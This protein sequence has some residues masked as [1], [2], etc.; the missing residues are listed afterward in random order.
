MVLPFAPLPRIWLDNHLGECENKIVADGNDI[1][2]PAD[3]TSLYH[4]ENNTETL[5]FSPTSQ[6]QEVF[7]ALMK[8][9]TKGNLS[10]QI[11]D[12]RQAM[13][14]AAAKEGAA[15][16]RRLLE[17][18]ETVRVVFAAAPSQNEFLEALCQ[19]P[20]VDWSR[21][22]AF[23]MDEYVGLRPDAPQG[24]G[25]FLRRA[26]FDR[27]PFGSVHYING[28]AAD[29]DAECERYAALLKEAPLDV[30][31]L[32]IG[33][34]GHIAFNAPSTADLE[35]PKAVKPV[36]LDPICR[37]QQVHDG[38]FPS[39]DQ[40][41]ETAITL[42][43]PTLASAAHHLCIVPARA[44]AN[45]VKAALEAPI[46]TTCPATVLRVCSDPVLYLDQDSASLL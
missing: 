32:S 44:K 35:D 23:H 40:V 13:A 46:G 42:T 4:M 11:H 26:I 8:Y 21:V 14:S 2:C 36:V 19:A 38:C 27:L 10:V 39:L 34:N 5:Y 16:L 3:L 20:H 41:P 1:F 12:T 18:Q 6:I 24:F 30:V 28:N 22:T 45:A 17:K 15:L 25:N 31:F 29:T 33:E 43:V 9:L 37:M 7:M